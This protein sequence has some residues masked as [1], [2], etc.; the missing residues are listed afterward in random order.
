[1]NKHNSNCQALDTG[2]KGEKVIENKK[3]GSGLLTV[4]QLTSWL[5]VSKKTIYKWVHSKKVPHYKLGNIL[6]FDRVV[7]Q[8]W[9]SER[10][11]HGY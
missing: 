2:V 3:S 8:A 5:N 1:M 9:L 7:I 6:R 11:N 4:D 10:S